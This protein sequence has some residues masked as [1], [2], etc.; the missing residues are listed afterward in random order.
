MPIESWSKIEFSQYEED[1][2][3]YQK[4][5]LNGNKIGNCQSV[6]TNN[7]PQK[8]ENLKVKGQKLNE[9]FVV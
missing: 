7:A 3:F 5:L 2:T 9:Y 8:F 1:G 6:M 4:L